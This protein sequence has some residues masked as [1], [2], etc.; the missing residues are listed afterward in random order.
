MSLNGF[1]SAMRG[2]SYRRV[3]RMAIETD[4]RAGLNARLSGL[5]LTPA[6]PIAWENKS[7]PPPTSNRW[8]AAFLIPATVQHRTLS[9]AGFVEHRGI[10]Q[11]SVF[12]PLEA[13]AAPQEEIAGA[14]KS[15]FKRGTRIY[16][17]AA[18]I[19]IT[20]AIVNQGFKDG[21]RWQIPVTVNFRAFTPNT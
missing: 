16:Q 18:R 7:F 17:G 8:L 11:I 4:I 3:A 6:H 9:D 10:Y 15:H 20:S 19:E 5:T 1:S 13:G 14:I 2:H 21:N 12:G